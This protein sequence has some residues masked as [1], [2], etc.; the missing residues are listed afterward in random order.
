[1]CRLYFV[2]DFWER[3]VFE[4]SELEFKLSRSLF[5]SDHVVSVVLPLLLLG[6]GKWEGKRP[7]LVRMMLPIA[8]IHG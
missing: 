8:A 7:L 4:E 6:Y 5:I 2:S 1:M 3:S